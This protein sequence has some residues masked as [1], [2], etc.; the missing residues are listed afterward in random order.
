MSFLF[1][2]STIASTNSKNINKNNNNDIVPSPPVVNLS[3]AAEKKAQ[4]LLQKQ[5]AE[6]SSSSNNSFWNSFLGFSKSAMLKKQQQEQQ[7]ALEQQQQQM[8]R[9]NQEVMVVNEDS[10]GFVNV[11]VRPLSY[12]EIATLS[13]I[14]N[15]DKY[16]AP[17][18]SIKL[19]IDDV[20]GSTTNM[21]SSIIDD[22]Y[23]E[24]ST[25]KTATTTTMDKNSMT[26][27][28]V[29][30]NYKT[31]KNI[32][33][34]HGVCVEEEEA[35]WNSHVDQYPT[36]D[37]EVMKANR[38]VN[39]THIK[40]AIKVPRVDK[41]AL[42]AMKKQEQEKHIAQKDAKYVSNT[43]D[44]VAKIT[45]KNCISKGVTLKDIEDNNNND[46]QHQKQQQQSV[47][48]TILSSCRAVSSGNGKRLMMKPEM[49]QIKSSVDTV[50]SQL[51]KKLH[52]R[53][54]HLIRPMP[55]RR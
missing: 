34:S 26:Q 12:A 1:G 51:E 48:N 44:L 40:K 19:S 37:P 3:I 21:S 24:E 41:A 52:G 29:L 28:Q 31:E 46:E 14:R 20:Y 10:S 42:V 54:K 11:Q 27:S 18:E 49:K 25:T 5:D 35:Y 39:R 22:Y 43:A 17:K 13:H 8:I 32:K 55:F 36:F 38:D 23:D 50:S 4:E 53:P 7:A 16:A 9:P 6:S 2:S 30:A 33:D 45:K 47:A 15:P